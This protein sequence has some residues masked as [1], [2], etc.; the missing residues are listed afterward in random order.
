[1]DMNI[2][3]GAL[4]GTIGAISS[5]SDAHR[6]LIAAALSQEPCKIICNTNSKDIEATVGCLCALGA[7]IHREGEIFSVSPIEKPKNACLDCGESGS[8]LRF[9]LPVAAALGADTAFTGHGRLPTRPLS[10]LREELIKN[11]A[12]LSPAG[13]FPVRLSGAL[14]SGE[15]TLAGNISSQ[16]VTG[17]LF[18]LPLLDG[19]SVIHLLPPVES[20][21]YIEMTLSVLRTF[22]IEVKKQ[23]NSFYIKGNQT[24]RAPETVTVEGD[25]SNAAF[26]LTAGALG[27]EVTVTGLNP[28]SLQGDRAI[29]EILKEMGAAVSVR[30]NS[31]T[32]KA[33]PLHGIVIDASN[34]PDLVPVLSIAAMGASGQTIIKN[35]G[36]LRIKE[37]DRLAACTENG[38]ALGGAV[39]ETEDGLL[40]LGTNGIRGGGVSGFNDHRM[41]MSAAVAASIAREKITILGAEA[42][43]KSYPQFFEDFKSL[44]GRAYGVRNGK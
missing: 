15:F 29:A 10:P 21:A 20:C 39:A 8:T 7:E 16:F 38:N 30:E 9:L 1:M 19:D 14:R 43:E 17:L 2:L 6:V 35:A 41:V 42:A 28:D 24:Y 37:C 4:G 26:F 3:P 27:G 36:R 18:A 25:W 44:G 40:I 11:G 31:V 5:K 32:V 34:I 13:E 23:E 22:G 33:R 12:L